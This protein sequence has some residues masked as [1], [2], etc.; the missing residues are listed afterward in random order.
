MKKLEKMKIWD[1]QREQIASTEM[2]RNTFS[3]SRI[4]IQLKSAEKRTV[5]FSE[6][7]SFDRAKKLLLS[8]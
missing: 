2:T 1:V 7:G 6:G 5:F 4:E 8:Q 3:Y